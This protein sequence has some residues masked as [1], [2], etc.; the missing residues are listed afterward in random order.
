[1]N[2]AT[3][4]PLIDTDTREA[5]IDLFDARYKA[6]EIANGIPTGTADKASVYAADDAVFAKFG[7]RIRDLFVR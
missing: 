1:M 6:L 5:M 7:F 3:F 4:N 2:K